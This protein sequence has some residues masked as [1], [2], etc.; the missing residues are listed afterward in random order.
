MTEISPSLASASTVPGP[1]SNPVITM[2][3]F[4]YDAGKELAITMV[5]DLLVVKDGQHPAVVIY[6]ARTSDDLLWRTSQLIDAKLC[7]VIHAYTEIDYS[8]LCRGPISLIRRVGSYDPGN[9]AWA[10]NASGDKPFLLV[11]SLVRD[12]DLRKLA[13]FRFAS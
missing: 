13:E 10:E 8:D 11:H 6:R 3:A 9:A 4:H 5:N 12:P 2:A 1:S 7:V